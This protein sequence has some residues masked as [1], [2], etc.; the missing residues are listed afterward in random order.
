M[1][2]AKMSDKFSRSR[3]QNIIEYSAVLGLISVIFITMQFYVK[4]SIQAGIKVSA[5]QLG[6]QEE[7]LPPGHPREGAVERG[8]STT[9]SNT[10]L[11]AGLDE[12]RRTKDTARDVRARTADTTRERKD[13]GWYYIKTDAGWELRRKAE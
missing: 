4:R 3:A 9:I 10:I 1:R 13:D 8:S 7:G 11:G 2:V 5:D 12:G 6:V